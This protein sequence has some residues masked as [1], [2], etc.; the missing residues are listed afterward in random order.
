MVLLQ[1]ILLTETAYS[2]RRNTREW[3]FTNDT[4]DTTEIVD[5]LNNIFGS[6]FVS[7]QY[8]GMKILIEYG[9]MSNNEKYNNSRVKYKTSY[10]SDD[11]YID[12]LLN[13]KS[14][15]KIIYDYVYRITRASNGDVSRTSISS[16]EDI[17]GPYFTYV[18]SISGDT[19]I[20]ILSEFIKLESIGDQPLDWG[21]FYLS[22][23][24]DGPNTYKLSH[25]SYKLPPAQRSNENPPQ[26]TLSFGAQ[27]VPDTLSTYSLQVG[28]DN[29]SII[30]PGDPLLRRLG[31]TNQ[32][33][34]LLRLGISKDLKVIYGALPTRV[35]TR[36]PRATIVFSPNDIGATVSIEDL[37]PDVRQTRPRYGF[38]RYDGGNSEIAELYRDWLQTAE[39]SNLN[40]HSWQPAEFTD[41]QNTPGLYR[42]RYFNTLGNELFGLLVHFSPP[43]TTPVPPDTSDLH[44]H[45]PFNPPYSTTEE[46]TNWYDQIE[47]MLTDGA[48]PA[49]RIIPSGFSVAS[50]NPLQMT[51]TRNTDSSVVMIHPEEQ[52]WNDAGRELFDWL[53]VSN[54]NAPP[55]DWE[56]S[57]SIPGH[58]TFSTRC[59]FTHTDPNTTFS[60]DVVVHAISPMPE[61]GPS[62]ASLPWT[63]I[64]GSTFLLTVFAFVVF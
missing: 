3:Q 42:Y 61:I 12:K 1:M 24:D 41:I 21:E 28:E 30:V 13:N 35:A 38:Q 11:V 8:R 53:K 4:T 15:E 49:P 48:L 18:D 63:A 62:E 47:T 60:F 29:E 51:L 45:F 26:F 50:T 17:S 31:T 54:E 33:T 16:N 23:K 22:R 25:F 46:Y 44:I 34:L 59:Q 36:V 56:V 6:K 14:K 27:F 32:D 57:E 37:F 10:P 64:L 7:N 43:D 2:Q 5:E 40:Q 19:L 55:N 39:G 58:F 9:K 52:Y 20:Q